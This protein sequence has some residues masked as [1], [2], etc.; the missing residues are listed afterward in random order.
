MAL[1]MLIEP[2]AWSHR[3]PTEMALLMTMLSSAVR[4]SRAVDPLA[5]I[6]ELTVILPLPM[7]V[8]A[9]KPAVCV[10]VETLTLVPPVRP[11]LMAAAALAS[12]T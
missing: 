10:A 11:L 6:A 3:L 4:V 1:L 9:P 7:L 5:L 12:M 2:C 8:E